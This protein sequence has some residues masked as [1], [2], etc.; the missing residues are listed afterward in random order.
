M[1]LI[2]IVAAALVAPVLGT[3]CVV[4]TTRSTTWTDSQPEA[5]WS[6]MPLQ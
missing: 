1:K 6:R 2:S 3:G 4:T 5:S